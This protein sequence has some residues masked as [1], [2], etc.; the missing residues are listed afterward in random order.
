M[1]IFLCKAKLN[2]ARVSSCR[3]DYSGSIGVDKRVLKIL[4][5][6]PYERVLVVNR[7][8]GKRFETYVVPADEGVIELQ[9][10]AALLGQ[11]GDIIGFLVF[12]AFDEEEANNFNPAIVELNDKKE[13]ITIE[14]KKYIL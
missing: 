13:I 2:K 7:D 10:G 11:V 8:N 3:P 14:S 5:V 1:D 4:N 12:A 9:G 6:R